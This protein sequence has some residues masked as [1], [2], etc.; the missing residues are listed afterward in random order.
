M[1]MPWRMPRLDEAV[2]EATD[3]T[4]AVRMLPLRALW[5]RLD[6]PDI[7]PAFALLSGYLYGEL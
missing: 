2:E 3:N 4:P 7:P 6:H 1:K 5:W